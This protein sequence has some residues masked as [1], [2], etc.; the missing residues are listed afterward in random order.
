MASNTGGLSSLGTDGRAVVVVADWIASDGPDEGIYPVILP[1]TALVVAL[2][3]NG[4]AKPGDTDEPEHMGIGFSPLPWNSP[5]DPCCCCGSE[6]TV[7][8]VDRCRESDANSCDSSG[9]CA[10][11]GSGSLVSSAAVPPRSVPSP[12][13]TMAGIGNTGAEV[14]GAVTAVDDDAMLCCPGNCSTGAGC[15]KG[16]GRVVE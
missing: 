4:T 3:I 13:L 6:N 2:D 11:A 1:A 16:T 8:S 12:P 10:F 9:A 15:P 7:E 14:V 5:T